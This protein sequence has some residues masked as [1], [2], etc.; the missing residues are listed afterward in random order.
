VLA[1]LIPD[2]DY[3]LIGHSDGGSIGLILAAGK[4]PRLRGLITE[5]AHVLVE[6]E[7]LAGIRAAA[8]AYRAGRLHGL[9]KY[10][11][12]K[13]D[14]IFKAWAD[15]WLADWFEHWNIKHLLPSIQCP[16]LVIQGTEDQYGTIDQVESIASAVMHGRKTMIERCGHLPHH[17]QPDVVLRS[18]RDFLLPL[19]QSTPPA[20]S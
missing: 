4:P 1:Q 8:E 17:E 10:H 15:T 6:K 20:G 16:V 2:R 11:G 12:A 14:N 5:A 19:V 18:M 9:A 3:F 7:T 13:T